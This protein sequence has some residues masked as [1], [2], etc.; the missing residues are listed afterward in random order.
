MLAIVACRQPFA[1][2]GIEFLSSPHTLILNNLVHDIGLRVSDAGGIYT[3]H[4]NGQGAEAWDNA[5]D[6]L[7]E[8]HDW[9]QAGK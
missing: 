2:S 7:A 9:L 8:R 3:W 1:R 5:V 6:W 4:T